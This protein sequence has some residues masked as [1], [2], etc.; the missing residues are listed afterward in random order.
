MPTNKVLEPSDPRRLHRETPRDTHD[1]NTLLA[2]LL[3]RLGGHATITAREFQEFEQL[4]DR[5]EAVGEQTAEG[6]V[7]RL[8]VRF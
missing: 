6:D 3:M 8:R 5:I 4:A 7:V 2:I 1:A